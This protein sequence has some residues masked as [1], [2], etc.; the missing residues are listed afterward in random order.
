M[1]V[2]HTLFEKSMKTQLVIPRRSAMSMKQKISI[3]INDLNR[4]L[5]NINIERMEEGEIERVADQTTTPGS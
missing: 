4:R 3:N 1:E 2:N 5:S